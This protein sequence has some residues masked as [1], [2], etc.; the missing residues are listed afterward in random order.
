[1]KPAA[2]LDKFASVV[3]CTLERLRRTLLERHRLE[4]NRIPIPGIPGVKE[5]GG[6]FP[7]PPS[8]RPSLPFPWKPFLTHP[9]LLPLQH[10][11]PEYRV[12]CGAEMQNFPDYPG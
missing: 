4:K 12:F 7:I 6:G 11:T 2:T 5:G 1:M 3:R 10:S 9:S 8:P